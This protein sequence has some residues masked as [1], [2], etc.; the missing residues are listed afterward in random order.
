[1][2]CFRV[3]SYLIPGNYSASHRRYRTLSPKTRPEQV[4]QGLIPQNPSRPLMPHNLTRPG[5]WQGLYDSELLGY[6]VLGEFV[7]TRIAPAFN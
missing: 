4:A 2:F 1:M 3:D 7:K 5:S 6:L